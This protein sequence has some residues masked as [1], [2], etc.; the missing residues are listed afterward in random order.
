MAARA[1]RK[2]ETQADAIEAAAATVASLK[3]R[4]AAAEDQKA[5]IAPRR[6][7][8]AFEAHDGNEEAAAALG[9]LNAEET[10]ADFRI[11]SLRDAVDEALRREIVARRH[12][13]TAADEKTLAEAKEDV[14]DL[15]KI[16][17]EFDAALTLVA[18]LRD[19]REVVISRLLGKRCLPPYARLGFGGP[20]RTDEAIRFAGLQNLYNGS[21]YDTSNGARKLADIDRDVASK[22]VLPSVAARMRPVF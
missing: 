17:A 19:R 16:A 1:L 10:D 6:K 20:E 18:N 13:D 11:K 7:A 15:L 3:Q 2:T 4:L 12:E 22:L 21:R 8:L 5:S 9:A 14:A